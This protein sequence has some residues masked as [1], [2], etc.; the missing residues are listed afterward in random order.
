MPSRSQVCGM[1]CPTQEGERARACGKG[2]PSADGEHLVPSELPLA[3]PKDIGRTLS[4]ERSWLFFQWAHGRVPGWEECSRSWLVPY[5]PPN[6]S[7]GVCGARRGAGEGPLLG[8]PGQP[9]LLSA[10]R[11]TAC[12]PSGGLP[13]P[14]RAGTLALPPGKA[15]GPPERVATLPLST[16]AGQYHAPRA[17]FPAPLPACPDPRFPGPP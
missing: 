12:P 1:S 8:V 7:P 14:G 13:Q 17:P 3:R 15:D 4:V 10:H 5:S 11:P 9:P 2:A 6:C 16:P